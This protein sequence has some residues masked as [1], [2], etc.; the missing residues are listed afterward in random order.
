VHAGVFIP[1]EKVGRHIYVPLWD[2]EQ[3]TTNNEQNNC[4]D[5]GVFKCSAAQRL[6]KTARPSPYSLFITHY[7][8]TAGWAMLMAGL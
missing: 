2:N 5:S 4:C 7:G 1:P 8:A 6:I 3:R